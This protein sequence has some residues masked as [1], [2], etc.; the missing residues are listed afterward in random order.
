MK[1]WDP[2]VVAHLTARL[3]AD[4][5]LPAPGRRE[6]LGVWALSC[7][8]R[9]HLDDGGT[10]IVKCARPPFRNEYR[11]IMLAADRGIPVPT[12]LATIAY[13]A[14]IAMLLTDLGPISRSTEASDAAL[15]AAQLHADGPAD[16]LVDLDETA[17]R[18]L[19]DRTLHL[20]DEGA[21]DDPS[22]ATE[23]IR[24]LLVR[25]DKMAVKRAADAERPPYGMCHGELHHTAIHI[26]HAGWTML[27]L[28]TAHNGP[29][30]LDLASWSGTR[31]P[32]EPDALR[33]LIA[34][35]V[36]AGGHPDAHADRGGLPAPVWAAAWHRVC[37]AEWQLRHAADA[38]AGLQVAARQ[39]RTA[40]LLMSP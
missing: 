26:G 40:A 2:Q 5:R 38:E 20:L 15:A 10:V 11:A 22:P 4:A 7:V 33:S 27:D 34:R 3:C 24:S 17:L 23:Q 12:V 36:A 9:V 18:A 8:E 29:G 28:A 14:V 16:G 21:D 39:L 1:G 35:Y 32:P 25:L 31:T 30:L 13:E 37:A 19:P 6:P